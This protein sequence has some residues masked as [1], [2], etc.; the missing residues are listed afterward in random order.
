MRFPRSLFPLA[1][2]VGVST[3]CASADAQERRFHVP[4]PVPYDV[5]VVVHGAP[6]AVHWF[7]GQRYVEGRLGERYEIRVYNRTW[8]RAEVVVSVDGRDA[9]DGRPASTHKRGYVIAPGAFVGIDGFRLS[10][11]EVAAFRFTTVPD[12]YAARMGTPYRVGV[13]DVAVFPERVDERRVPPPHWGPRSESWDGD[14]RAGRSR[15]Q[16]GMGTGF[17]E[18]RVSPVVETRFDRES[19][20]SP[21]AQFTIRY[22]DQDGLCA[23][24]LRQFCPEPVHF[25]PPPPYERPYA[26]PPPGWDDGYRPWR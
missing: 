26:Q 15:A 21:A 13:I 20:Y 12:S 8:R 19:W 22:D 11:D 18:R 14:D 25:W 2:T 9:V 5:Q 23:A 3:F 6:R 24:G 1:V 7:A 4:Q 16:P 17:G 10:R